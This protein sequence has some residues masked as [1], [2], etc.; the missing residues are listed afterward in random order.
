MRHGLLGPGLPLVLYVFF[1]MAC[2]RMEGEEQRCRAGC[3]DELD[4]LPHYNECPLLYNFFTS[5]WRHATLL[6]RRGHL[7]HDF[8]TKIFSMG[9]TDA[10]SMPTTTTTEMW[11]NHGILEIVWKE[12]SIY[13]SNHSNIRPCVPVNPLGETSPCG[14]SPEIP[15][16][17]GQSQISASSQLSDHN[18]RKRQ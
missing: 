6:P 5:V 18:A 9:V 13:D 7:L 10:L 1:A 8:I 14:S 16:T 17:C 12:E 4:S 3:Q 2:V 11:I 15:L